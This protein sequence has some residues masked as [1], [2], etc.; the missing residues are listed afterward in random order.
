ML[1]DHPIVTMDFS[2]HRNLVSKRV[3]GFED[4]IT[5]THR[6]RFMSFADD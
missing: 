4:N 5:N 6:T 3:K 1:D 2:T